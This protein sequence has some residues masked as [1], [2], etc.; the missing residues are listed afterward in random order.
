MKISLQPEIPPENAP[1][2]LRVV[3]GA[4]AKPARGPDLVEEL[5]GRARDELEA[6]GL[7]QAQAAREMGLS[8]PALSQWLS[9]KYAGDREAVADRVQAW[10]EARAEGA[11]MAAVLPEPPGWTETPTGRRI[12]AALGYAQLA[13]DVAL[14]YGGAGLGKTFTAQRYAA[15]K[16]NVWIATMSPATQSLSCCL[17]RVVEACG[18]RGVVAGRRALELEDALRGRVDGSRGLLVVDEAQHLGLRALEVLR[19]LHDA[20]GAGVVLMGNERVYTRITGVSRASEF[21]QLFSRVGKRVRLS[22][23]EKGDVAKLLAAWGSKVDVDRELRSTAL[24]IARRPGGLRLVTKTLRL[25]AMHA[26][27]AAVKSRHVWEAW[28][29][30]G[31]E[32]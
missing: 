5:R 10:L 27:G 12:Y 22:Q 14:V 4:A 25:A 15:K 29:E 20:T 19:G 23:V 26:G 3:A 18:L 28:R 11:A 24:E 8:S 13:G 31:G 6:G 30:I 9:G 1:T 7:S 32:S 2:D 21:A 17:E 16:P